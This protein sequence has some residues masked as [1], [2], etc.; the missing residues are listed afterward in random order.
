MLCLVED[1]AEF[2]LVLQTRTRNINPMRHVLKSLEKFGCVIV[3]ESW[4]VRSSFWASQD[5][6]PREV[7]SQWVSDVL[8][9]KS[10]LNFGSR[11][12]L[13]ERAISVLLEVSALAISASGNVFRTML[14]PWPKQG[15]TQNSTT[16]LAAL[17]SS[18]THSYVQSQPLTFHWLPSS[19]SQIC[20]IEPLIP[21]YW[22][23]T[24]KMT[25]MAI[26]VML[27]SLMRVSW[28]C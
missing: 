28:S 15:C 12:H 6:I 21:E 16:H 5:V 8:D 13:V 11:I 17:P 20:G 26:E 4:S 24:S 9:G 27:A 19:T 7:L 18:A 14:Q 2:L 22:Q 23:L 3:Q 25:R 10:I 1:D